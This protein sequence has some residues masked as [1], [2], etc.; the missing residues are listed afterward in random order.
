MAIYV[1]SHHSN[2]QHAP[3][4][5]YTSPSNYF[6]HRDRCMCIPT[7]DYILATPRNTLKTIAAY[8]FWV[9]LDCIRILLHYIFV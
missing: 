9:V 8:R 1:P 6:Q 4:A 7:I 2:A 5:G 3:A